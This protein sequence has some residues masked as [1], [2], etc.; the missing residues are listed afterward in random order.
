MVT[1]LRDGERIPMA[2]EEYQALD[3]DA[4]GE[5]ID[6]AL[7][8]SPAPSFRHDRILTRVL[9]AINVY[10]EQGRNLPGRRVGLDVGPATINIDPV[11]LVH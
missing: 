5:Y 7:V 6:G 11:D 8:V 1:E 4:R 9:G 3:E 2:W 10:V